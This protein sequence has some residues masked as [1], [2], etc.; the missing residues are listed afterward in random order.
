MHTNDEKALQLYEE[1]QKNN[2]LKLR[3]FLTPNYDE[4]GNKDVVS[5]GYDNELI[6]CHR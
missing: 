4:I 6:K 2:E 3:I 5:P 1:L